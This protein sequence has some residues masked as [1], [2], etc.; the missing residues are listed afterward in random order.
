[1]G[2]VQQRIGYYS[3]NIFYCVFW[4][5]TSSGLIYVDKV[6]FNTSFP[7]PI[8]LA[9]IQQG[10][11]LVFF[12]A[13]GQLLKICYPGNPPHG[14]FHAIREA[15]TQR[16]PAGVSFAGM[17][18]FSTLCLQYAQ[19][20]TYL[21]ARSLTLVFVLFLS[22]IVLL[23]RPSRAAS[24]CCGFVMFGF[25]IGALDTRTLSRLG[26][27]FGVLSSVFQAIYNVEI[28]YFMQR[29]DLST[30]FLLNMVFSVALLT[31]FALLVEWDALKVWTNPNWELH[32]L[33][34]LS[35]VHLFISIRF[36]LAR[37]EFLRFG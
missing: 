18:A 11:G 2:G 33:I 20:S 4:S 3:S 22:R 31:P 7:F 14:I 37:Q 24:I 34:A 29:I 15:F 36:Q 1:M 26:V 35:G 9:A 8:T 6:L 10:L 19:V 13:G 32:S 28:K 5:I 16:F 21:T 25:F 12:V 23:E 30:L 17:V 27:L